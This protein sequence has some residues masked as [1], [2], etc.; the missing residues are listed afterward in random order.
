M[1]LQPQTNALF[2]KAFR[3]AL[4]ATFPSWEAS[5]AESARA[6]TPIEIQP[7]NGEARPLTIDVRGDTVT[8][9]PCCD[10]GLDYIF[11]APNN[12]LEER[13]HAVFARAVSEISDFV[14]GRTVVAATRRRWLFIKVGWDVRFIPASDAE[15]ASRAGASII[16][17]NRP[18]S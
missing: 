15:N 13:P 6:H 12:D 18:I 8:L 16:A 2:R 3:E 9:F 1:P 17:W 10:F 5:I 7:P 11:T 4:M 14:D